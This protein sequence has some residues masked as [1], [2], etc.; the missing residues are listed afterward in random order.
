MLPCLL[1][2]NKMLPCLLVLNKMLTC[3]L[4][5]NKIPTC[6][7]VFEQHSNSFTCMGQNV[8]LLHVHSYML[9]KVLYL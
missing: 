3:L 9:N 6:L 1:V 7:R 2:L 8:N 4:V 5:L